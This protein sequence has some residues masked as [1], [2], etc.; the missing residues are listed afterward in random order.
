MAYIK[1]MLFYLIGLICGI[2]TLAMAVDQTVGWMPPTLS[3]LVTFLF[4]YLAGPATSDTAYV[5]PNAH[6]D[7]EEAAPTT[8]PATEKTPQ[9]SALSTN[10]SGRLI[11][12]IPPVEKT[13]NGYLLNPGTTFQL[14]LATESKEI[15]QAVRER[16]DHYENGEWLE[17]APLAPVLARYQVHCLE[18]DAYI[19]TH[20]KPFKDSLTSLIANSPEWENA[21][22]N[23]KNYMMSEFIDKAIQ[24]LPIRLSSDI[25]PLLQDLPDT[26]GLDEMIINSHGKEAHE[27]YMPYAAH[28]EKIMQVSDN[29]KLVIQ[30]MKKLVNANL[31]LQGADIPQSVLLQQLTMTDLSELIADCNIHE[32][33]KSKSDAISLLDGAKG[34]SGKLV[35]M[36]P[37]NELYYL[38]P[39]KGLTKKVR[40]LQVSWQY[41][42]ALAKLMKGTYSVARTNTFRL[43]TAPEGEKL[44]WEVKSCDDCADCESLQ[45][46]YEHSPPQ[47]PLH[48]GCQCLIFWHTA[49]EG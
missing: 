23:D 34:V 40:D 21:K 7:E 44:R 49:A 38:I 12:Q 45:L 5:A 42:D 6:K 13:A 33:A 17:K 11:Y 47:P 46:I 22:K 35:N 16:I 15:A 1:V 48:V 18:I 14:T 19:K 4:I 3:G 2:I 29:D 9:N 27:I 31:C 37:L 41:Y 10:D 20:K 36:L 8:L 24:S 30:H 39:P 43:I 25:A 26:K 32:K 28:I